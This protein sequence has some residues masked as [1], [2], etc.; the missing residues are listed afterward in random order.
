MSL[1]STLS[2]TDVQSNDVLLLW[3]KDVTQMVHFSSGKFSFCKVRLPVSCCSNWGQDAWVDHRQGLYYLWEMLL[4]VMM[5][6]L[7]NRGLPSKSPMTP[8]SSQYVEGMDR[9]N[10]LCTNL[11]PHPPTAAPPSSF[12]QTICTKDPDKGAQSDARMS[13]RASS[14]L[15]VQQKN[16]FLHSTEMFPLSGFSP[17]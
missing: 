17:E 16:A 14:K 12:F 1:A 10:S 13:P 5:K 15:S 2:Q 7:K 9:R 4:A 8:T 3:N 11:S 6:L